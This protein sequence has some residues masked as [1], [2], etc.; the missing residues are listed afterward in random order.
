MRFDLMSLRIAGLAR[1]LPVVAALAI[2]SQT[3]G[4]QA[5]AP[6]PAAPQVA[7][8]TTLH[9]V[10]GWSVK[11]GKSRLDSS[12]L[13]DL[14]I[15]A[16]PPSRGWTD[17][18]VPSL[19]LRCVEHALWATVVTGPPNPHASGADQA[20]ISYQIDSAP[21][22]TEKWQQARSGDAVM[23]PDAGAFVR[24][25]LT[26]DKLHFEGPPVN[27]AT[28][29]FDFKLTGLPQVAGQLTTPC[30]LGAKSR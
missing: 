1:C 2:A 10:G 5:T 13:V 26:A 22:V 29:V 6:K 15:K 25:L 8:N 23:T 20:S 27:G 21:R 17:S 7:S 16:T 30:P 3:S 19:L 9:G 24:K 11:T 28:P 12:S 4:A 14:T 18:I